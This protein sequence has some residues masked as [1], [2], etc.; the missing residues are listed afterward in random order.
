LLQLVSAVAEHKATIDVGNWSV[1]VA[2]PD[3]DGHQ[4]KIEA[5]A[6]RLGVR[7]YFEFVGNVDG[8][9][10]WDLYRSASLFILPTFSE[11]FGLVIAEALGCG[12]PVITTQGAPWSELQSNNCGWWY[13]VGQQHLNEALGQA[14]LTQSEVLKEMGERGM[15]LVHDR[16]NPSGHGDD[17]RSMYNWANTNGPMPSCFL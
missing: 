8:Q 5:E 13:P 4:A 11:N 1:I 2:G 10:K 17:F 14:L 15:R 16:Y 3:S 9:Q 7:R 12:V 6:S